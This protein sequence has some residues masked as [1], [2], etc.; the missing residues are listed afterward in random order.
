MQQNIAAMVI[1]PL[2]GT[3]SQVQ[4]RYVHDPEMSTPEHKRYKMTEFTEEVEAGFLVSFPAKGH[5]IRV[6][7][8]ELERI[9][10]RINDP[11]SMVFAEAY[12]GDTTQILR[13]AGGSPLVNVNVLPTKGGKA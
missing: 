12:E 10:S 4:R 7:K 3:V 6:D 13:A 11:T 8:A 9:Q 1:T 5:S 2:P